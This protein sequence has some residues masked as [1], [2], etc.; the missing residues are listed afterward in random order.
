M[1]IVSGVTES[2]KLE[3]EQLRPTPPKPSPL[4]V[5]PKPPPQPRRTNKYA[6]LPSQP[7]VMPRSAKMVNDV[8]EQFSGLEFGSGPLSP[9]TAA[10]KNAATTNNN[11]I[12][13]NTNNIPNNIPID[14]STNSN[15]HLPLVEYSVPSCSDVTSSVLTDNG[16]STR[17]HPVALPSV[18]PSTLISHVP[19]SVHPPQPP[20]QPTQSSIIAPSST[21]PSTKAPQP[22]QPQMPGTTPPLPATNQMLTK[23]DVLKTPPGFKP[24]DQNTPHYLGS[25]GRG[26][27]HPIL[28]SLFLFYQCS[29]YRAV[30]N[31]T[32]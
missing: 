8:E 28:V 19:T 6:G 1:P 32:I 3:Q 26:H 11:N 20:Q 17:Q 24:L 2:H 12:S 23:P 27:S 10:A 21:P 18:D 29:I 4:H 15:T 7:V 13:N 14:A 16:S 5:H 30:Q 25:P 22:P 9:H 31:Q